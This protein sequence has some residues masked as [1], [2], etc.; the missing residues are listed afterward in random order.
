M[1]KRKPDKKKKTGSSTIQRNRRWVIW[2]VPIIIVLFATGIIFST[3]PIWN[4]KSPNG[5]RFQKEGELQFIGSSGQTIQ[6]IDIEIAEND[7]D[8]AQGL[9]WRKSLES[10]QG[11]LFI[12]DSME[13]Q[14]FWMLNT[15]I[16]LDIIFAD[17]RL[18]IVKIRSHAAP[19]SLD[20]VTSEL[21][22]QYVVEVNAGFC[23]EFGIK[24]GDQ[25]KFQRTNR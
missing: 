4:S 1:S 6:T 15:Y 25:I 14:S 3:M 11:M 23:E 19:Q 9:M 5:P 10:S 8:R 12:M 17:D 18:K 16:P 20:P 24:E 22:A 21:P 7:L 13:E 2:L